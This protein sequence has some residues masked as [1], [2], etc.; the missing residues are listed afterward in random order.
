MRYDSRLARLIRWAAEQVP[1][2]ETDRLLRRTVRR[3]PPGPRR[4]DL[5][6]LHAELAANKL[7]LLGIR[8]AQLSA[9]AVL[10]FLVGLIA[11]GV[12]P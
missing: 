2:G 8:V 4:H 11:A 12:S 10:A 7:A 3:C 9:L 5:Q 1:P 6:R